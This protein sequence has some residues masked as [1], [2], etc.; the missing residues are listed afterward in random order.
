MNHEPREHR[1][2]DDELVAREI[3]KAIRE[4]RPVSDAGARVIS[5]MIHEGQE[6]ALYSLA[7]SGAIVDGL[8]DELERDYNRADRNDQNEIRTWVVQLMDY[9]G[10][11]ETTDPI[12]GW[13]QLWLEQ[14]EYED[15]GL[16]ENDECVDCGAHVSDPHDPTCPRSHEDFA[17]E[18]EPADEGQELSL[19]DRIKAKLGH[20]STGNLVRRMEAAADFGYDDEAVELSRRLREQGK[21]WKWSQS[22]DN[23]QVIIYQAGEGEA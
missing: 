2:S 6:S 11:R 7:S 10:G 3:A 19:E 22:F 15:P 12:D 14:P 20:I 9:I 23:P 13:S 17:D 1:L 5:S 8:A 21:T 18:E 4:Q 16:D